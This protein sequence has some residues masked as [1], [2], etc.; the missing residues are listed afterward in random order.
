MQIH[1]FGGTYSMILRLLSHVD[2]LAQK[3][4]Q[5]I[6]HS[7]YF[8]PRIPFLIPL[9]F[10]LIL[11]AA[12][13]AFS[14]MALRPSTGFQYFHPLREGAGY[15][16]SFSQYQSW[17]K[18]L[19]LSAISSTIVVV[20]ITIMNGILLNSQ[21]SE[22]ASYTVNCSGTSGSPTAVTESAYTDGDS[23]T[24]S[25]SGGDGY[26]AIDEELDV[27]NAGTVIIGAGVVLTHPA[28]DVDGVTIT[29]GTMTVTGDILV[30][31]V[32]CQGGSGAD[33]DGYGPDTGSGNVCTVSTAGGGDG[34]GAGGTDSPGGGSHGGAGGASSDAVTAATYGESD[35]PVLLGSGGGANG[36]DG[37]AGGGR[38]RIVTP[39][40]NGTIT[41]NGSISAN[42][43]DGSSGAS[44]SGAGGSGGSISLRT[45]FL[46]GEGTIS[47]DG[48]AGGSATSTDRAGAG[49][50]G[51][52][53]GLEIVNN[54]IASGNFSRDGG[55]AGSVDVNPGTQGTST[56]T[57]YGPPGSPT[58]SS[59]S[60]GATG[61]SKTPT[62]TTG[63]YSDDDSGTHTSTDWWVFENDSCTDPRDN[64]LSSF[65]DASNLTSYTIGT[66]LEPHTAYSFLV[67]FTDDVS[68]D[69]GFSECSSFTTVNA[70]P[71]AAIPEPP[72]AISEDQE[73]VEVTA[74]GSDDDDDSVTYEWT[75]T[76]DSSDACEIE[77]GATA[78]TAAITIL[79]KETDYACVY[80]VEVDDGYGGTDTE[81]VT[82]NVS[83]DNDPPTVV[84]VSDKSVTAGD[85]LEFAVAAS[86]VDT[87]TITM[88]ASDSDG[89]FDG[90]GVDVDTL[91]TDI[92][93]GSGQF[94]W[95]TE[96]DSTGSFIA[97]INASDGNSTD[98]ELVNISVTAAEDDS[99]SPTFTGA[100]PNVSFAAGLTT[101]TVFDLDEYFSDPDGDT[102]SY[103]TTGEERVVPTISENGEVAFY[104]PQSFAGTETIQFTAT[105]PD[106]NT[107]TSNSITVAVSEAGP[108]DIVDHVTGRSKGKGI[109]RVVSIEGTEIAEWQAFSKG[110][111]APRLSF[112]NGTAYVIAVKSKTGSTAHAY[113]YLGELQ[114]KKRLSPKL[115]FR[116]I[117]VGNLDGK[118]KSIETVVATK[119]GSTIYF[120]IFS[121]R[122]AKQQFVLRRR[123][124]YRGIQGKN[125]RAVIQKERIKLVNKQ[126]RTK[127]IWKPFE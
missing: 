79:N 101:K 9:F 114:K 102:L 90:V 74:S 98:T 127:F 87:G 42:G 16:G 80:E 72:G 46:S 117:A 45:G 26:C 100:L 122:T 37:G 30:D 21:G 69:S 67:R 93:G 108:K 8:I 15:T 66:T 94:T 52:R 88:S 17:R 60:D 97:A 51:G 92:G 75:E 59:P 112:A 10:L 33:A 63:S 123:A 116:K 85:T 109:I 65:P 2:R 61:V 81:E 27:G 28:E 76:G 43:A 78:A 113:T 119:R 24:F 89:S 50:G 25:D 22:A 105:D 12:L 47:V 49:G 35:I 54:T 4:T 48:G 19:Q 124:R 18:R 84:S 29:T 36:G 96:T 6:Q 13:H 53:I 58:I 77:S 99:G 38:V 7:H 56:T 111:V 120:K 115:H 1:F 118:K 106:D 64:D 95:E 71:T 5:K 3:L 57:Q 32:G 91:F 31:G 68:L 103:T 34:V 83:A 44:D 126:G 107:A 55:A 82:L 104:A 73:T 62:I 125:Y 39:M 14:V 40:D 41:V 20:I 110:G 23:V 11:S 86:D 70:T 121:F